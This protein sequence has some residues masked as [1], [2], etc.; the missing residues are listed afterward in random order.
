M[1]RNDPVGVRLALEFEPITVDEHR[2]V[3]RISGSG[4]RDRPQEDL[5]KFGKSLR[6]GKRIAF[7][8][9]RGRWPRAKHYITWADGHWFE[10][11][12]DADCSEKLDRMFRRK[13]NRAK[14]PWGPPSRPPFSFLVARRRRRG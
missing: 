11:P 9:D 10:V 1:P 8:I 13:L 6:P 3:R 7:A 2:T 14:Q 4:Y 5:F 12:S